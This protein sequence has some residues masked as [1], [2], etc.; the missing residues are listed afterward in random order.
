MQGE[1]TVLHVY[2]AQDT[3]LNN[4]FVNQFDLVAVDFP[5]INVLRRKQLICLR[6]RKVCRKRLLS[7]QSIL[8]ESYP[9][10]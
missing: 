6:V 2:K 5:D 3:R 10:S 7:H 8:Y 9:L 1:G 4:D